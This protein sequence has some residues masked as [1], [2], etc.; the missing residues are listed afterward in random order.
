MLVCLFS[1]VFQCVISNKNVELSRLASIKFL[2][3]HAMKILRNWLLVNLQL[4]HQEKIFTVAIRFSK[5]ICV[6]WDEQLVIT[7]IQTNLVSDDIQWLFTHSMTY[8]QWHTLG[9]RYFNKVTRTINVS[10]H[11]GTAK[12]IFNMKQFHVSWTLGSIH[13]SSPESLRMVE[14]GNLMH[15]DW[16]QFEI[17]S[18]K[19]S[20]S[21]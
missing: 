5:Y 6:H 18:F 2:S 13:K 1:T 19:A 9:G 17:F 7:S 20:K 12:K 3:I 4:V 14:V 21:W 10:I 8:S 11:L 16:L 15:K